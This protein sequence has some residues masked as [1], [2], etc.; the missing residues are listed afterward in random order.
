MG[1]ICDL[2][3]FSSDYRLCLNYLIKIVFIK[4]EGV[5]YGV[6]RHTKELY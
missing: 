3:I 2:S 6:I 4:I 1:I 5:R